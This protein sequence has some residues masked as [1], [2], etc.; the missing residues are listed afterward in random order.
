MDNYIGYSNIVLISRK[1]DSKDKLDQA[2]INSKLKKVFFMIDRINNFMKK[3]FFYA[4]INFD[5]IKL[6]QF[7]VFYLFE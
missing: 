2:N 4:I 5:C 3:I 6:S 1:D 7:K